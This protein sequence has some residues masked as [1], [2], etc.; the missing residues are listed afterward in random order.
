MQT[1]SV[2]P[3]P[4]TAI[5]I[6]TSFDILIDHP[7]PFELMF[8][9]QRVEIPATLWINILSFITIFF[10]F[11][12][13]LFANYNVYLNVIIFVGSINPDFVA[14]RTV[15]LW[16]SMCA[17]DAVELPLWPCSPIFCPFLTSC[18]SLTVTRFIWQM[19]T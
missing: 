1:N 7:P 3:A 4:N 8:M 18:P 13:I 2:R 5:H 17:C 15:F 9:I 11:C 16:T 12:D 19:K 10:T 14:I 6:S